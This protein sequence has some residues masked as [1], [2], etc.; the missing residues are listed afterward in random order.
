M[1]V[2]QLIAVLET[3]RRK[4]KALSLL[5]GL[6]LLLASVAGAAL[7]VVAA[8]YILNLAPVPRLVLLLGAFVLMGYVAYR[9]IVRPAS[10]VVTLSDMAGRVE[11][12]FPQFDDRLRSAINFATDDQQVGSD[13]MRSRVM[14][15]AGDIAA[16]VNFG[17]VIRPKPAYLT[18]T[19]GIAALL[20]IALGALLLGQTYRGIIAS[21][22]FTPFDGAAW[23]TAQVI[24]IPQNLPAKVPAGQKVQLEITIDKGDRDNLRPIAHYRTGDGQ[25]RQVFLQ[26]IEGNR[27]GATLDTRLANGDETAALSIRV[28]AGDAEA[29]LDPVQVVPRLR[30]ESVT[31]VAT[32]P[33]YVPMQDAKNFDLARGTA[34][35]GQGSTV[36]LRVDFNK[37]LGDA[38]GL[39]AL[40][41]S[42]LPQLAWTIDN[43]TATATFVAEDSLRFRVNA[44][45]TDGFDNSAVGEYGLLVRPDQL[46]TI[47]IE[48]PRRNERRTVESVVPIIA[49]AEDDYGFDGVEL[50]VRK[51][52]GPEEEPVEWTLPLVVDGEPTD[53]IGWSRSERGDVGVRYRLAKD[54]ALADLDG[55]DLEPGDV[56]EYQLAAQDNYERAGSRHAPALSGKLRITIISQ[57]DLSNEVIDDMRQI[58]DQVSAVRGRQERT[59]QET[60]DL[61]ED[62]AE[63]E[64]LDE[65]DEATAKRLV[66]DQSAAAGAA[67]RLAQQVAELRERLEENASDDDELKDLTDAVSEQ[68]ERVAEEPMKD[69]TGEL[70]AAASPKAN[71]ERRE[72]ALENA[73]QK[74]QEAV[75]QL[76][77]AMAEMENIGSLRSAIEQLQDILDK[78]RKAAEKTNQAVNENRGKNAA[79]LSNEAK[80]QLEAAAAEQEKV[81]EQT[82][83]AIEQMEKMAEQM[84]QSDPEA[85]KA[86][87]EAA[88]TAQRR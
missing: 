18:V 17:Q 69:A 9:F 3:L 53:D 63:R 37:R 31:A 35:V 61:A 83:K 16:H 33:A 64:E 36:T 84:K 28:E 85:S 8:D 72:N 10:E 24:G 82:Q 4:V 22:L 12:V 60:T 19:G 13:R 34:V 78:Q 87:A 45:D 7:F 62:T 42:T 25:E 88:R 76:E 2:Q 48:Q 77:A 75:E 43:R 39:A 27:Y 26:R 56:L 32:P 21:R 67:K 54:W 49:A 47:V 38:I 14:T 74:Q 79:D 65:A 57:E 51:L 80:E 59:R 86:M 15:Q 70:S 1:P 41:E 5:Y 20:A 55:G 50:R 71:Q 6:G 30:V 81:A 68:L 52:G 29:T 66:R 40:G 58:R 23:P 44:T 11:S 73:G 46:P